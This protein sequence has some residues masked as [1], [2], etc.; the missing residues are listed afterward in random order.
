MSVRN[1]ESVLS[2]ASVALIGASRDISSVGGILARNL[3]EG[4]FNGRVWL[5]NPHADEL[6][7]R[8]VVKDVAGLSSAPE[9]AV[10][11]TPAATVPDLV[12]ELGAQG[13]KAVIVLSAGF[14][15]AGAEGVDLQ[16]KMLA[17]AR[18]Y[19]LRIVGPNCLGI[20]SPPHGLNASFAHRAPIAGHT[21][22]VTQSGAMLT[23]VL[24]WATSHGIGFSRLVSLGGMADVDF[25]DMLDYLASDPETTAVLLYVE[26]VTSARKFMSAARRCS[27]LK[28]VI[29]VKGGRYSDGARAARS[30]TG[31][32]AGSDA[33]Y[34]AAFRRAGMLRVFTIEDLFE[35]LETVSRGVRMPGDRMAIITNGGGAGVLATDHL[36]ELGGKLAQLSAATLAALNGVLPKAWSGGNP[37][38][39]IGDAGAERYR[40]SVEA[41]L[42]DPGLDALLVINCPVAVADS[43]TAADAVIDAV[44]R[45]ASEGKANPVLASWLGEEAAAKSRLKFDA[46]KLPHFLTPEGAISAAMRSLQHVR[47]QRILMEAPAVRPRAASNAMA[48]Q[49]IIETAL[50]N[51]RTWLT[52]Q[53]SNGLLKA[54]GIPTIDI[55]VVATPRAAAQAAAELGFPVA[56]KIV[57]KE[58]VHKSDV[59][60][61]V[62]NLPD[63]PAV[64][65]EAAEMH[66]SVARKNPN[67]RIDGFL[68]QPM[69]A[70]AGAH[71]L[72]VGLSEDDLFGPVLLFGQGGTAVEVIA[73]RA[74]ALPP[75][76]SLL[77]HDMIGRTRVARLLAGYR[78]RPAANV[79]AIVDVLMSVQDIAVDL[80]QVVEIDINPLWADSKGVLA[81]DAR[82]RISATARSGTE[83]FAIRPYPEELRREVTD[84]AGTRYQLRPIRPEDADDLQQVIAACEP[85]DRYLRFF[86]GLQRLPEYVAKGLTQI[87]YDRTMG[88]V[89]E[90]ENERGICGI[91]H[92]ALDPDRERG[93][94]AVLV[95]SDLKGTGL[96]F[97]LVKEIIVYARGLKAKQVFGS[98]LMENDRMLAMCDELGFRRTGS[99]ESGVIEVTLDL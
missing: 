95:R 47:A 73:D 8:R 43:A 34:D 84:R 85:H 12:A 39:I 21:A 6:Y 62:L 31:A 23:A 57:S 63:G 13:T 26:S 30:H 2:P 61:V 93:E 53:E 42:A 41:V 76:N 77:A 27:R 9:L 48:G 91:V 55:R 15:E 24:D 45:A 44:R 59:G 78:D 35:T 25:G 52:A 5:V 20:L 75:I 70:R 4:S 69:A 65:R 60:G 16:A 40:K 72:I 11:A 38:D 81:L 58:I 98:V 51:K 17:A 19:T 80:P 10:I 66:R 89:A 7:G 90:R 56:L 22:F 54:Y 83:R 82:V 1:L 71:E 87:D 28:P 49:R 33:V 29:V 37:I 86:T 99:R 3:C 68:V 94:F 14:G 18:P 74:L 36:I 64:E 88:F 46:A 67:A 96:G 50:A 79:E 32:L 92:L 97:A